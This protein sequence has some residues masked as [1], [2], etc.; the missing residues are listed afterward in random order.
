MR[1]S[2]STMR[3]AMR[4]ATRT[5]ARSTFAVLAPTLAMLGIVACATDNG[6]N[7]FG[8]QFTAPPGP[9]DGG[10]SD[11]PESDAIA[12]DDAEASTGVDA[13]AGP[14]PCIGTGTIAVL[15]GGDA[16]LTGSISIDGAAWTGGAIAS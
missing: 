16:T 12:N 15:A 3:R 1:A 6:A 13:E 14:P 11:G 9:H 7:V 5:R 8:P 10:D 4:S 2:A